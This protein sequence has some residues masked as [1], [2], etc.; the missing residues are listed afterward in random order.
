MKNNAQETEIPAAGFLIGGLFICLI[1]MYFITG[2]GAE[3]HG[4]VWFICLPGW[5]WGIMF[6]AVGLF[7]I[8]GGVAE[9]VDRFKKRSRIKKLNRKR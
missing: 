5:V 3:G 4:C 1:S 9:I 8:L 6:F 7:L 2:D